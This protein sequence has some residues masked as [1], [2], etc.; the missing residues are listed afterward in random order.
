MPANVFDMEVDEMF[1]DAWSLLLTVVGFAA[2]VAVARW[3]VGEGDLQSPDR[4]LDVPAL[5]GERSFH[6]VPLHN[7]HRSHG[8]HRA[9]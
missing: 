8:R 9:R 7:L 6:R 3:G 2:L 1:L 5:A 4:P